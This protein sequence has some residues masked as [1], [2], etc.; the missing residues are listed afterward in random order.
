MKLAVFGHC[1]VDTITIDGKSHEQ[2]GGSACYCGITARQFKFD[3]DAFTNRVVR[4]IMNYKNLLRIEDAI[5]N[6]AKNFLDE[7]YG[8]QFVSKYL[9]I[10]EKEHGL[11]AEE[12]AN[13]EYSADDE[14]FGIGANP[15]GAGSMGGGA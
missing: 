2:I 3:V 15:A 12:F 9:E 10:L 5:I 14:S 4:L 13:V 6:R 11:S 7:N 1:A 8:D